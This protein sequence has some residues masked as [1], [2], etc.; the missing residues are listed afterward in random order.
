MWRASRAIEYG[1]GVPGDEEEVPDCTSCGWG[2]KTTAERI[3][4]RIMRLV[5]RSVL[6]TCQ[7]EVAISRVPSSTSSL[8][9]LTPARGHLDQSRSTVAVR[10]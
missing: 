10:D 5:K 7:V 1:D 3:D 8:S 6:R 9:P 4:C 2:T